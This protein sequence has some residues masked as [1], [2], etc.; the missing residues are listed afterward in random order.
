MGSGR[1]HAALIAEDLKR[2]TLSSII[3]Q[4]EMPNRCK[5]TGVVIESQHCYPSSFKLGSFKP[6]KSSAQLHRGIGLA[7][8][9]P[10]QI[11]SILIAV[12]LGWYDAIGKEGRRK[13]R[14][15][16]M[17]ALSETLSISENIVG[18]DGGKGRASENS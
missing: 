12:K 14:G 9:V 18:E 3:S 5:V 11:L 13:R 15:G 1:R 7:E 10:T 17:S 16:G 2:Q 6:E 8:A 4:R